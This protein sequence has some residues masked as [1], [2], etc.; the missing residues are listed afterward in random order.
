MQILFVK[1]LTG[2]LITL[3]VSGTDTIAS[4]KRKISDK[5]G[6]PVNQQRLVY[7]NEQLENDKTLDDC[8]IK[9]ESNVY[10]VIELPE[11]GEESQYQG[12]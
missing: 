6:T 12:V 2:S 1:T 4:V 8:G 11:P 10:L 3:E 9:R 5:K 7:E